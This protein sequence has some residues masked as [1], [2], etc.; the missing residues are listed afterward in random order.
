MIQ[1]AIKAGFEKYQDTSLSAAWNGN[2]DKAEDDETLQVGE[3]PVGC[4]VF[5]FAELVLAEAAKR[6]G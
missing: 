1:L 2:P 3:Y 6:R 4:A 5:K